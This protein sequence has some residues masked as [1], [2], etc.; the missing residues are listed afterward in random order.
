VIY[1]DERDPIF[2]VYGIEMEVAK[3]LQRKIWLKSGAT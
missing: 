1:F 3:L 2:E